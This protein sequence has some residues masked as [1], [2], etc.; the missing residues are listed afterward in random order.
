MRSPRRARVALLLVPLVA[1]GC[2]GGSGPHP[3][4]SAEPTSSSATSTAVASTTT[5]A[6]TTSATPSSIP[7]SAQGTVPI[8][9]IPPGHPSHWIPAGMPTT[10][11]YKEPGDFLPMFTPALFRNDPYASGAMVGFVVSTLNWSEATGNFPQALAAV[12]QS[13]LCNSAA[14][15][16]RAQLLSKQHVVGARIQILST[17]ARLAPVG[18]AANWIIRTHLSTGV[19]KVVNQS[20]QTISTIKPDSLGVDFYAH[21][22]GKIWHITR[23]ALVGLK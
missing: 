19:G 7:P 20:G 23:D 2:S 16:L 3:S 8:D 1:A 18:S 13:E 12:C 17:A 9:Q 10:A 5:D 15:V 6:P 21:W 11:K 14:S 22:T 4:S